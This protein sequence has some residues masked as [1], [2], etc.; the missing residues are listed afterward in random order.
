M[1]P[2]GP[3]PSGGDLGLR[4]LRSVAGP[5]FLELGLAIA[6]GTAATM[7]AARLSDDAAAA[8]ALANHVA[9]MLFIVFRIV[10]AGV[11]VVVAQNLGAGRREAADRVAR[12]TMGAGTWIGGAAALATAAGAQPLLAA[13]G[14]PAAVLPWAVPLLQGLALSMVLDAWNATMGSVLRAHLRARESLMVIVA[15]QALTLALA[16]LLMPRLGLAG[17]AWALLAGRALGLALHLL[18][19][20]RSLGLRAQLPDAWRLARPELAAVLRIGLPA[21]AENIAYRL[22]FMA[23]VAVAGTLGAAALA[24]QAYALQISYAV[25]MAGLA[26]GLAAEVVVGHLVGAGRLRD[27]HALVR[28]ALALG[29][30]ISV[31]TTTCVALAGPWLLRAFTRDPQ[32]VAAGATL[33]WWTVLLEP[34]R[35]FNLV[36]INAL[37]AAGDARYPVAVGAASR[38]VVLAG[39]SWLLGHALG[40]GLVG[41]W[42]AYAADEWLRGVLMWRRWVRLGWVPAAR[43]AA[44]ARP[45]PLS[46]RAAAAPPPPQ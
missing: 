40:L 7:L 34:G 8:F 14:A 9:A 27:A 43:A 31:V 6:V 26:I 46:R 16:V 25:V 41:V 22:C 24:T 37:R 21:A 36:V 3:Q 11:G 2:T 39:G 19:W 15:M 29:L 42:I 10:G 28:R 35:T 44:R 38:V 30:V 12:A 45:G 23:S 17:Y 13:L 4:A 20:R 5:L 33:L 18:L 32:I 1:T